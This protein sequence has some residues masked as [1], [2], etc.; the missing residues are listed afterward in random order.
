ML[1]PSHRALRPLA[2]AAV[3]LGSV[4]AAQAGRVSVGIDLGLPIIGAYGAP[5]GSIGV[6]LGHGGG[7]RHR[8]YYGGGV[9]F[10]GPIY[11]PP[12]V[13]EP[14]IVVVQAPPTPP[15]AP[16]PSRADPVVYPRNG[17]DGTQTEADRQACDRWATTQPAALADAAV[18]KRAVEAC[19]DAR[20]YTLK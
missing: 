3:L 5:V 8:G 10:G 2:L 4:A 12:V 7:W 15:A 20:G 1:H 18:F 9:V 19:M 6:H 16:A 14:P 11:W 13:Y 17:Q